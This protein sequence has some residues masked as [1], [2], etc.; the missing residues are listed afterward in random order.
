MLLQVDYLWWYVKSHGYLLS[1]YSF[2]RFAILT[3]G[4]VYSR[5]VLQI[6]TGPVTKILA[7]LT[8]LCEM[9]LFWNKSDLIDVS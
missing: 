3:K 6:E 7:I 9:I 8:I 5:N 4:N 2:L 1:Y